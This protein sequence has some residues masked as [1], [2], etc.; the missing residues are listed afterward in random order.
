M[1]GQLAVV[2]KDTEH[3]KREIAQEWQR[4]EKSADYH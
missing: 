2:T 1:G 3:L 4:A